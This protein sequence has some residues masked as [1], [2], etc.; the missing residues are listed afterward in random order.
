M[1]IREHINFITHKLQPLYES[2]EA[3][4]IAKL[5]M[6]TK[7][8]LQPY[9]LALRGGELLPSEQS[10]TFM[11]DLA[12]LQKGCPVQYVLGTADFFGNVFKVTPDTLIP[13]PETE[14]LV[15]RVVDNMQT[16]PHPLIWD[17][18]T[19][20]GCI[21]ITLALQ[22]PFAEVYATDISAEVLSVAQENARRLGAKVQFAQHDMCDAEH[23]PFAPQPFDCMVSNPPYIPQSVRA[24]MHVNVR[25]YE[26]H[27]ALF[28]PD[29]HPLVFYEALA[30]LG[31]KVLCPNGVLHAETYE[32]FHDDLRA[33]FEGRGYCDFVSYKDLNDRVRAFS[34][35]HARG[36]LK[37]EN[38]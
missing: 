18:G 23:L 28:V 5:Y 10:G 31:E 1:T 19:G 32:E 15:Q 30:T 37:I 3:A 14:E 2:R 20:S 16:H 12:L 9:E 7:L 17:V 27:Q 35:L 4:A 6:Q 8:D 22:L 33:M 36:K 24:Q 34:V 29:A 38:L 13:R 25:E 26:P 11:E 21:A